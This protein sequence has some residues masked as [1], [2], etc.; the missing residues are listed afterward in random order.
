MFAFENWWIGIKFFWSDTLK[1]LLHIENIYKHLD[2]ENT[3][4]KSLLLN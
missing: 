2:L 1:K 4:E 3:G